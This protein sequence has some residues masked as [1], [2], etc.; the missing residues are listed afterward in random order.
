LTQKIVQ[1]IENRNFPRG[2]AE[3]RIRASACSAPT[4]AVQRMAGVKG[5]ERYTPFE[6]QPWGTG[7]LCQL[8]G[9][10]EKR[11]WCYSASWLSLM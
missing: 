4:A 7:T 1:Y 11:R 5:A 3:R 2:V 10:I 8:P 9:V 6:L